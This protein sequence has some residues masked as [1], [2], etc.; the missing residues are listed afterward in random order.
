MSP[1]K[2][3]NLMDPETSKRKPLSWLAGIV[4]GEGSIGIN[5]S[6]K[7]YDPV[8]QVD[9]TNQI[10]IVECKKVIH[11][12][13]VF[14]ISVDERDRGKKRKSCFNIRV[15]NNGDIYTILSYLL[16]HLIGKNEQARLVRRFI[17]LRQSGALTSPYSNEE[18]AIVEAV[19]LLNKKG[20]ET[21]KPVV[22]FAN[23]ISNPI[24]QA[25]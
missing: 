13:G 24:K 1:M 18:R 10:I 25:A 23:C 6:G 14:G 9:N 11:S 8:F 7:Y 16:P 21:T 15:Q 22:M 12:M 3:L 19:R 5:S 17:A 2:L 4:D 20:N